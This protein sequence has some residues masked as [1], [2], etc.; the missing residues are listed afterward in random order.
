LEWNL[1]FKVLPAEFE[2]IDFQTF[3]GKGFGDKTHYL[4]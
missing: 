4:E 1:N 3:G 2:N